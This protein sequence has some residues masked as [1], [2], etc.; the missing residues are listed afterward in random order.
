MQFP[1]KRQFHSLEHFNKGLSICVPVK[2]KYIFYLA[3]FISI[4]ISTFHP[5]GF[6]EWSLTENFIDPTLIFQVCVYKAV[7]YTLAPLRGEQQLKIPVGITSW[8]SFSYHVP[9]LVS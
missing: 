4:I 3:L 1:L 8:I 6:T 5:V 9:V 2:L 7:H